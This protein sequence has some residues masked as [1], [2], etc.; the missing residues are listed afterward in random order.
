M[1]KLIFSP[2]TL[3]YER[4]VAT[5]E[6]LYQRSFFKSYL[7]KSKVISIGNL[8]MG[9]TGKTPMTLLLLEYFKKQNKKVAVVSRNY[10]S[11]FKG[12]EKVQLAH[13]HGA[14]YYGDEA[15]MIQTHFPEVPIYVGPQKSK[16]V[17]MVDEHEDVD[18]ILVDDG[19]QH[20][21]LKRDIDIVLLDATEPKENYELIPVGRA[22][23]SFSA[24]K[25][26]QIVLITKSNF[27]TEDK[28][29]WL[30][31][32]IPHEKRSSAF[33]MEAFLGEPQVVFSPS[34]EIAPESA[35]FE[36]LPVAAFCGL[37][38]PGLFFK[39]L[40][41]GVGMKLCSEIIFSDHHSY[42]KSD[43]ELLISENPE[44]KHFVTTEKD[45][46]KV[47]PLWPQNVFLWMTP[48]VFKFSSK[49]MSLGSENDFFAKISS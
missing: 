8:T 34:A 3:T 38:K 15:Y 6:S 21:A 47:L 13:P 12:T 4:L 23:E 16:T 11:E 25:R 24:L 26:A 19:F 35:H 36:K 43:I 17:K 2:L 31:Q 5:R 42:K 20:W 10:K 7:S 46:K 14:S 41:S 49:K 9:G 33:L 39:M 48:L 40:Q 27:A 30:I 32:K 28:L 44:V 1:K 37:A 22:R 18:L 45:Y 29:N